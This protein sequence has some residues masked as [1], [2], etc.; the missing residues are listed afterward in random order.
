M[1]LNTASKLVNL[2]EL[3]VD[4]NLENKRPIEDIQ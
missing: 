2:L 3:I 4:N 1:D